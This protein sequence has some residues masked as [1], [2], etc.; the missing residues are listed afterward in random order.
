MKYSPNLAMYSATKF[1]VRAFSEGLR[2]EV[3][4]HDIRVTLINPGMVDT[5]LLDSF[6]RND[7]TLAIDKGE[8]LKPEAIADAVQFA[9]TRP[10]G[11][12]LNEMTIRPTR[13]ER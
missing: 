9:I 6:N 4:E 10:R 3:Q 8:I 7:S 12:A 1:A 2:N 11:V 13:Q 5:D